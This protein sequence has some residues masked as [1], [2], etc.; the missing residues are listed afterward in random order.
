MWRCTFVAER[1]FFW[2]G[3][4]TTRFWLRRDGLGSPPCSLLLSGL[5]GTAELLLL[6]LLWNVAGDLPSSSVPQVSGA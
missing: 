5:E 6:L 1:A 2:K 4:D 3:R